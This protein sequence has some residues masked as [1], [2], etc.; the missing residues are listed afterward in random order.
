VNGSPTTIVPGFITLKIF[1]TLRQLK[2]LNI[3]SMT[4]LKA[5]STAKNLL[6]VFVAVCLLASCQSN[7]LDSV[8]Y[9]AKTEMASADETGS[10]VPSV[11]ITAANTVFVE[12]VDCSTCTYV[13]TAGEETVDGAKLGLKPGSVICLDKAVKYKNLEFV[14]LEG[15][16][17]NQ[18]VIGHCNQSSSL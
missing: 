16:E 10:N 4:Y 13:V 14:N 6:S 2:A 1:L 5:F 17:G 12:S 18:I 3:L 9:D 7:E 11:T 15:T 8:A